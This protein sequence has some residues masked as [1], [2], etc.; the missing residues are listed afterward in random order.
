[1]AYVGTRA[2][3]AEAGAEVALRTARGSAGAGGGVGRELR[4][5]ERR[6][7]RARRHRR[8]AWRSGAPASEEERAR[9]RGGGGRG[10]TG[11]GAVPEARRGGAAEVEWQPA[12]AAAAKSIWAEA[13]I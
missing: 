10:A 9:R 6:R 11:V 3:R 8:P 13:R 5:G 2:D 4:D 12:A 7:A 1:M